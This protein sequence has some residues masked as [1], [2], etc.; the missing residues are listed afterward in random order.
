MAVSVRATRQAIGAA[1]RMMDAV[2]A[3][4]NENP[5]SAATM[6]KPAAPSPIPAS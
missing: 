6:P 4:A 5:L 2:I 3:N 1:A